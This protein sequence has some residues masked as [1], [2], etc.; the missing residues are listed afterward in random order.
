M[1]GILASGADLHHIAVAGLQGHD[2]D[3]R[4]GVDALLVF[5][6]LDG[7]RKTLGRLGKH[8]RRAGVQA[9]RVGQRN[10][11]RKQRVTLTGR[12]RHRSLR[13]RAHTQQRLASL[14]QHFAARHV[15]NAFTADH[16]HQ[17][18]QAACMLRD[19]VGIKFDQRLPGYDLL[20]FL[21]QAGEALA[22][23]VYRVQTNVQQHLH[24]AGIGNAHGMPGVLQIADYTGQRR[25]E[26]LRRRVDAQA[27]AHQ[28]AGEHRVR[29]L[30][31]RHQDTR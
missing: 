11:Q 2:R 16:Q 15:G 31:K 24:P 7:G 21:N 28:T 8:R 4:F 1:L 30:L 6:Q 14:D 25:T 12:L 26:H 23:E 20:A 27:V 22:A 29:H 19:V 17:G 5:V 10:G 9:V 3:Q 18:E 13:R